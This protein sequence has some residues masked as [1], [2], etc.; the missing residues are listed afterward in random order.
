MLIERI[1][2]LQLRGPGPTGETCIPITGNYNYKIT[3]NCPTT[4]GFAPRPPKP[5]AAG[6]PAPRLQSVM[7][8]SYASFLNT[9]PK[10]D[11]CTFQ[12]LV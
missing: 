1:N 5:P 12:L 3:K 11:T 2:D 8:L 9:F 6:R 4:G 7:R 10:L